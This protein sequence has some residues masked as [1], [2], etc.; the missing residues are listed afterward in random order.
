MRFKKPRRQSLHSERSLY[1]SIGRQLAKDAA[2]SHVT[3]IAA[4]ITRLRLLPRTKIVYDA[5]VAAREGETT[6][7]TTL[8]GRWFSVYLDNAKPANMSGTAFAGHL[9]ALTNIGLYKP[10]DGFA[11]G[12]VK[13]DS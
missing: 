4:T 1:K 13:I 12:E 11:W 2:M 5:L 9:A 10:V 7:M 6:L 8:P 3:P